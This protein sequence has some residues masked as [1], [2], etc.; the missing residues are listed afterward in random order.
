MRLVLIFK[1]YSQQEKEEA[2]FPKCPLTPLNKMNFVE[3]SSHFSI[4]SRSETNRPD[5][6]RTEEHWL[7]WK[8]NLTGN[9]LPVST[10]LTVV[11]KPLWVLTGSVM[12]AVVSTGAPVVT[13][14]GMMVVV[15]GATV[16]AGR[17][18]CTVGSGSGGRVGTSTTG[19]VGTVGS[20][21]V[22]HGPF[23]L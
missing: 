6:E 12:G 14:T 20:D 3:W 7:G 4:L 15:S 5:L 19:V 9:I 2:Y 10:A 23:S 8:A 22:G 1:F 21:F 13:N 11:K 18:G 16:V 17:V